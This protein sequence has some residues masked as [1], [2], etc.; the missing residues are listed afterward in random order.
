MKRFTIKDKKSYRVAQMLFVAAFWVALWQL[1]A[2][3]VGQDILLASPGAVFSRLLVLVQGG[4]FWQSV[5]FSCGKIMLGVVAALVAGTVLAVLTA[6]SPFFK[7]LLQPVLQVMKATPIASVII[8]ALVW[9]QTSNLA[10]FGAFIM[11]LPMVWANISEGIAATDPELLEMSRMFRF[12]WWK[13]FRFLY[14]PSILPYFTAALSSGIGIGW[15]AGVAAEVLGQPQKSIGR[16]LYQSK[17][18]LETVDLF[19]WTAVIILLSVLFEKLAGWIMRLVSR[20]LE[21]M[22]GGVADD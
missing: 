7:M 10:V 19:C 9:I 20:R 1:V 21:M 18:Y 17:I 12:S 16:A 2:L 15:K 11:V 3:A 13:T 4:V 5:L 6:R 22:T 14:L 8:M